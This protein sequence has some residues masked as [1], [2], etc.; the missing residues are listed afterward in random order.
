MF[1]YSALDADKA[2]SS[3]GLFIG[4]NSFVTYDQISTF[5]MGIHLRLYA[6]ANYALR[7]KMKRRDEQLLS[8]E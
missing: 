2:L 1:G 4:P 5:M 8:L 3:G 6:L 7:N